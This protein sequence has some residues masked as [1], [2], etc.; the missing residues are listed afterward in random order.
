[1]SCLV[2]LALNVMIQ[3]RW[4]RELKT[5]PSRVS[6]QHSNLDILIRTQYRV[7]C[8]ASLACIAYRT[9]ISVS[10]RGWSYKGVQLEDIGQKIRHCD[11]YFCEV[12]VATTVV[13][14]ERERTSS[15]I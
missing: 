12:T 11:N 6:G 3:P 13:I 14:S 7:S 15:S 4:Y 8:L 10:H 1:M 9:Q 2:Q 5:T